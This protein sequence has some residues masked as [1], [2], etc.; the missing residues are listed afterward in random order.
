MHGT[1]LMCLRV[2]GYE[3]RFGA[4]VRIAVAIVA[5][6]DGLSRVRML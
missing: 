1:W 2:R 6:D 3:Y 4:D 5:D